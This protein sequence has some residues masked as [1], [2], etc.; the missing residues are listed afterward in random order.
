MNHRIA[1][2]VEPL[3]HLLVP[4][5]G[6]HRGIASPVVPQAPTADAAPPAVGRDDSRVLRGEDNAMV[7]PYLVA[8]ERR[9]LWLAVHGVEVA[10]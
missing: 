9:V 4:G 3:L 7:R 6:R 2:L 1:R 5:R 10:A 8:H